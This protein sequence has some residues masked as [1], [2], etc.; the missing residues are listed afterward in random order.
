MRH[1]EALADLNS[2]VKLNPDDPQALSEAVLRLAADP[3]YARTLGARAIADVRRRF[4]V[5]RF[6]DE[7]MDVIQEAQRA[8]QRP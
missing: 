1:E 3:A 5:Q 6:E 2:L 4:T 8:R 7:M